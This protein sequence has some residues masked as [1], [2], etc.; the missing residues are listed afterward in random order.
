MAATTE[1]MT[2]HA[3]RHVALIAALVTLAATSGCSFLTMRDAP[4]RDQMRYD[5]EPDCSDG[6]GPPV[7]D[8]LASGA[9]AV[10]GLMM[11]ALIS[12]FG[13]GADDAGEAYLYTALFL[14]G[15]AILFGAS[16]VSGFRTAKS[17]RIARQDFYTMRA[18]MQY[19]PQPVYQPPLE[20][21]PG[22]AG[23]ERGRC[24][25]TAPACDPGLACASGFC[26]RPPGPPGAP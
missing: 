20:P 24:R 12:A 14:G 13:S 23:V 18:Q 2:R 21:P 10:T 26:V 17:C 8:L 4:P 19:G 6:R 1:V 25:L 11:F 3:S 15:P 7:A 22:P 16:S 5:I 9:A